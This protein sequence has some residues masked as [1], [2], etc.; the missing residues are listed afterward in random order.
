MTVLVCINERGGVISWIDSGGP[1]WTSS[2]NRQHIAMAAA[3]ACDSA[4][5]AVCITG[6]LRFGARENVAA[7][8]RRAWDRVGLNCVDIYVNLGIEGAEATVNHPLYTATTHEN[9]SVFM[10]ALRPVDFR[11]TAYSLAQ[12]TAAG[13]DCHMTRRNAS[14]KVAAA[15]ALSTRLCHK[16]PSF[17]QSSTRDLTPCQS[18]EC[19]HCAVTQYYPQVQRVSACAAMVREGEARLGRSYKWFV[20]HRPDLHI[21]GIPKIHEWHASFKLAPYEDR[22]LAHTGLFCGVTIGATCVPGPNLWASHSLPCLACDILPQAVWRCAS[23]ALTT[24][25]IR[26]SC[27]RQRTCPSSRGCRPLT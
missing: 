27:S 11:V 14:V 13:R 19:T 26:S 24:Q 22:S 9:A 6:Q 1:E 25:V 18:A 17:E 2:R 8:L 23:A 20:S 15:P 3:P 7:Q 12:H 5:V 21:F 10:N 16:G 4:S